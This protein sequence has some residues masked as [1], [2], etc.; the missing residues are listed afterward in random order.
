[1]FQVSLAYRSSFGLHHFCGGFIINRYW[2]ITAAHC[3]IRQSPRYVIAGLHRLRGSSSSRPTLHRITRFIRHPQYQ[4]N[5][6]D[7]ALVRVAEP[8]VFGDNVQPICAPEADNDYA[9]ER[10]VVSG[11]GLTTQGEGCR[12]EG[13]K[14]FTLKLEP[15]GTCF[16]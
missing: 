6:R 11:W 3:D 2:A 9:N 14:D 12:L 10:V 13:Q 1:M 7:I 8:F 16:Q 4:G 5:D 15:R